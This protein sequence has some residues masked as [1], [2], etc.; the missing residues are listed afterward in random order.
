MP[1]AF[2]AVTHVGMIISQFSTIFSGGIG[3]N[4]STVAVSFCLFLESDPHAY[5]QL[6]LTSI[7]ASS[8]HPNENMIN[9]LLV[10]F[11]FQGDEYFITASAIA[12]CNSSGYRDL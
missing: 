9:I 5:C 12:C 3:K 4:G 1:V 8:T 11:C 2:A 6:E 7:A 10:L